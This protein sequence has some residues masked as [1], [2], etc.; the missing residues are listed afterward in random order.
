MAF[1]VSQQVQYL[2][3]VDNDTAVDSGGIVN[4]SGKVADT[5]KQ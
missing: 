1:D 5:H 3:P 4:A 2:T